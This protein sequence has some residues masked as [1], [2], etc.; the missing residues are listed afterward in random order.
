MCAL[1]SVYH[2]VDL[3]LYAGAGCC[4]C[5]RAISGIVQDDI[6]IGDLVLER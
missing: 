5:I 6:G 1:P 4:G 2:I 3:L